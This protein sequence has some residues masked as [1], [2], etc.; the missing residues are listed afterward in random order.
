MSARAAVARPRRA[1]GCAAL[2][3]A[4][5]LACAPGAEAPREAA[6][7]PAPRDVRILRDTWGVPHVFGRT[8]ADAAFGLAW[9][10]AADDFGTIQEVVLAAR[11]RLASVRGR[12]A[13]AGDYV[14]ALLGVWRDV[15]AGFARL[16]A[17]TRA[18]LAG[19]A[20]GLNAWGAAHPGEVLP[21]VLPVRPEDVVAG[22]ALRA[23]FFFG[24]D[25][26][27]RDLFR[28]DPAAQAAVASLALASPAFGSNTFAVAPAR[29]ADGRARLAVNSHQPW[30]G[31]VA[32]YEAHVHSEDGWDAVGGIFPGAPVI[33]HGH[34]RHLGWAFTVNRPDLVDVYR[35][36][37]DPDDPDRYRFDGAWRRLEIETVEIPVRLLGPITWTVRREVARSVHGPVLRLPHGTYA[38][39]WAGMGEVRQVEQWYRLNRA[40]HLAEWE[41]A[42]R[43]GAIPSLNAG[44]ADREGNILYLHNARFPRR[45]AGYDW[46]G[47]LP[48]DTSAVVWTDYLPYEALPRV[49]NPP[50]GFVQNCNS[51]PFETTAGPGNPDPAAFPPELGIETHMTNRALRARELLAAAG[52]IDDA[53]FRAIKFDVAYSPRSEVAAL[54]RAAL[55]APAGCSAREARARE[56][57]AAWDLRADA[58]SRGAALGVL[59]AWPILAARRE[60]RPAPMPGVSLRAAAAALERRFGRIDP[61]WSEV[62]RLR[63]GDL[64]LGL[65]GGPDLLRAIEGPIERGRIVA[66]GGDGLLFLVSFGPDGVRSEAV[67][68]Y[69]AAPGRPDSPH[70]ADQAPLFAAH[71]TR[72]VWLD[73]AEIRAHLEREERPPAPPR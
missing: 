23:P 45:A 60:G 49:L 13:A 47:V 69:G 22:F 73:E 36:E 56:V 27:L 29:S 21:G 30:E 63:R 6:P 67:H 1:G 51:T 14:V 40:T 41:A 7:A 68:P 38:L 50:S 11:G 3:A 42:M 37:I 61:T 52:P 31:P 57:L 33:L 72:P 59:T 35:L 48:G 65:D 54:V 20:E 10:H 24:L 34:N 39:R 71:R 5:L 44:Y 55:E 9:A 26:V 17:D 62:L 19:Y 64:E 43:M 53:A 25:D 28:G 2:A 58:A 46:R 8:D 66:D 32:W 4:L 70:H 16:S 12:E 18:L 15:E